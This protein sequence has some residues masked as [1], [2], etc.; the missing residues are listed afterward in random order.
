MINIVAKPFVKKEPK[1]K[2][3]RQKNIRAHEVEDNYRPRLHRAVGVYLS[4]KAW[5]HGF[6]CIVLSRKNL[7]EFFDMKAT[8][9]NRM[10]QIRTDLRPWFQGFILSH[11]QPNNPTFVNFL[12]LVRRDKETSYFKTP[13][14]PKGVKLL[15]E[16]INNSDDPRAPKTA[17]FSQV[18]S[19]GRVPTQ[20]E[21]L[22]ELVL[23]VS[24][25]VSPK[26]KE[27]DGQQTTLNDSAK[28]GALP[29]RVEKSQTTPPVVED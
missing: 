23:V 9:A 4:L 19:E 22:S 20:E 11:N 12:F 18:A 7:L 17:L 3:P 29:G 15:I 6:D 13:L 1:P 26:I 21:L 10:E 5:T 16:Q 27:S 28:I 8:P 2:R 24:G 14:S 25:L